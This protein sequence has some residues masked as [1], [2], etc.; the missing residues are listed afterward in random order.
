LFLTVA[1]I[2]GI[3]ALFSVLLPPRFF[4]HEVD[5]VLHAIDTRL[6]TAD[7]LLLGDSVGRQLLLKY[8]DD[9]RFSMLATNAAVEMTGQYFLLRRFLEHHRPPRAVL[10]AGLPSHI[11]RNLE[12]PYTEN[13]VLRTFNDFEEIAELFLAT[14]NVTQAVKALVYRLFPSYKYRLHLQKQLLGGTNADIYTGVLTTGSEAKAKPYTVEGFWR[15]FQGR[16]VSLRHFRA[17]VELLTVQGI[18]FYYIPVPIRQDGPNRELAAKYGLL[19]DLLA[20]WKREGMNVHYYADITA[21]PGNLFQDTVHFT[22]TGL[23]AAAPY[24][25]GLIERSVSKEPEPHRPGD[26]H[27]GRQ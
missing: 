26:A 14:K 2:C 15:R 23:Q 21:L 11:E 24:V 17:M 3:E 5:S 27:Q 8:Q 7:Y 4:S 13:Y 6:F 16:N 18:P 25:D 20:G 1:L 10:F 9:Q 22:P 12:Q 19:F